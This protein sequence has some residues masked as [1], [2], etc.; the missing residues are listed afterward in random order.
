[1]SEEFFRPEFRLECTRVIDERLEAIEKLLPAY[2]EKMIDP[3]DLNQEKSRLYDLRN[4][5][6]TILANLKGSLCLNLREEDFARSC[7]AIAKACLSNAAPASE[8]YER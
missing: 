5:L 6:G 2:R 3:V 8:P 1:M 7:K 4:N